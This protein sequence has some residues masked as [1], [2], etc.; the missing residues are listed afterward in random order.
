LPG[1]AIFIDEANAALP[2][3]LWP[4][5]WRWLQELESQWGC[6]IVLGSGSLSRFW[7]LEE[8][9]NPP[10]LIPELINS[11]IRDAASNYE[12]HR[13]QYKSKPDVLSLEELI[14]W[15]QSLEGPRLL[16]VNTVQS[17]AVIASEIAEKFGQGTVEHLS[18]ALCPRDRKRTLERIKSR[19]DDEKDIDWILVATSCVEAGIDLS[20]KTGIRERC[21]LNSL[22]QI[23]GRV[24]RSGKHKNADVWDI[25]LRHDG[26]LRSHPAFDTSARVL[27]SLID[28]DRLGPKYCTEAMQNEIRSAGMRRISKEI[29]IAEQNLQFPVVEEKFHVIDSDTVTAIIDEEL[30]KQLEEK[31]KVDMNLIQAMSVQIWGYRKEELA[32]RPISGFPGMYGWS[33]L[34]DSFLGYMAGVLQVE[35]FKIK[36]GSVV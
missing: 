10:V 34:Y 1:S 15:V 11:T 9:S 12:G 3:H 25:R 30:I 24:N 29:I 23:G 18:T 26:L 35:A 22:I 28:R 8:F 20:F 4:Q 19:L 21:S 33:L 5:G 17:A 36:G 31:E 27:G 16:I 13:V 14:T 6:H 2:A 7:E 32:L